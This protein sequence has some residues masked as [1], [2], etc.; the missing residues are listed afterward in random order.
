MYSLAQKITLFILAMLAALMLW[1]IVAVFKT[2]YGPFLLHKPTSVKVMPGSN[3]QQLADKLQRK[4]LLQHPHVFKMLVHAQNMS[5]NL[6]FGEYEIKP[7]MSPA[8]LLQNIRQAK[9]FVQHQITFIEGWTF[10]Q[11]LKAI[12]N[13]PHIKQTLRD[14]TPAEIMQRLNAD[15]PVAEG[16]FF[17]STYYFV[18]GN[19]DL[20]ILRMAHKKM[21]SVLQQEWPKRAKDLPYTNVEQVLVVASLI[22]KEASVAKERPLIAGVI[23]NRLKKKMRL[24]IDP[25]VS[26]GVGKAFGEPITKADLK[27]DNPYNTYRRVGLPPTPIAMPSLSAIHAALNPEPSDYIF[28]VA[29]G[30]GS[31]RFSVTYDAHS[32]AVKQ[33]R[34]IER[35]RKQWLNRD[36]LE[37]FSQLTSFLLFF[38]M[39]VQ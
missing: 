9:G 23:L 20:D 10:A 28:Y 35:D 31:H 12:R 8:E 4:G 5:T 37:P 26:Y 39:M 15:F 30:D 17:P 21:R 36:W 14:R 33:Y 16:Q 24:Q 2:W 32:N 38:G 25:T 11:V 29:K 27:A 22:E 7:G 13:N 1:F 19:S 6:R 3:L 18:W 34:E